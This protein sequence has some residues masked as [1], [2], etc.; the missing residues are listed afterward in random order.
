MAGI[1]FTSTSCHL[2]LRL[3]DRSRRQQAR[4]GE[5]HFSNFSSLGKYVVALGRWLVCR[6]CARRISLRARQRRFL[7][8]LPAAY[9]GYSCAAFSPCKRLLVVSNRHRAFERCLTYWS[10]LLP[11]SSSDGLRRGNRFPRNYLPFNFS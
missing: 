9:S 11:R 7:P 2:S 8:T 6:D 4:S 10:Y 3:G 5:S 1:S